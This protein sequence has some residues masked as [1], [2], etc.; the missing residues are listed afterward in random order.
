M[1]KLSCFSSSASK[2]KGLIANEREA[3]LKA[4]ALVKLLL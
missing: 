3:W 2:Y 1:S 4:C